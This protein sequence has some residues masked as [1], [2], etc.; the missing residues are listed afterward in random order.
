MRHNFGES[1][2]PSLTVRCGPA[3]LDEKLGSDTLHQI[4]QLKFCCVAKEKSTLEA[5][6]RSISQSTIGLDIGWSEI[7]ADELSQDVD[8][9]SS[10]SHKALER[11]AEI[12]FSY[13]ESKIPPK[14]GHFGGRDGSC[15]KCWLLQNGNVCQYD[16]KEPGG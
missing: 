8:P 11:K 12:R 13:P 4:R 9:G 3:S 10:F 5:F 2:I 16:P 14:K 15:N 6:T 7:S 1:G